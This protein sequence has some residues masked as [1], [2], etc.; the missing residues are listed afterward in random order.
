LFGWGFL[1]LAQ[2]G[3]VFD[4]ARHGALLITSNRSDFEMINQYRRI[5]LEI[6]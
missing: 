4:G 5:Q 3:L 1:L 2:P 6:W